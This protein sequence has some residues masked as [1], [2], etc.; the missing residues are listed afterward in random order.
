MAEPW[1]QQAVGSG[2]SKSTVEAKASST[3][4]ACLFRDWKVLETAT[5]RVAVVQLWALAWSGSHQSAISSV[6]SRGS[7]LQINQRPTLIYLLLL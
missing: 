4:E 2:R 6:T 3:Q 5:G 1:I 7:R